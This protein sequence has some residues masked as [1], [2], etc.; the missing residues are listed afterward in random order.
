MSLSGFVDADFAGDA[1]SLKSTI[2]YMFLLG[3][4]RIP[5]HSKNQAITATSTADA[6]FIASVS[7]IQQVVWF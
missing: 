2:G 7:A 3:T 6:E 4:G 1:S 5:W